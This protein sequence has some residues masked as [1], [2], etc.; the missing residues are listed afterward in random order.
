MDSIELIKLNTLYNNKLTD[1]K[2]EQ[3]YSICL[4]KHK[5]YFIELISKN[6]YEFNLRIYDSK[7]NKIKFEPKNVDK[8]STIYKNIFEKYDTNEILS[9]KYK[10][11]LKYHNIDKKKGKKRDKKYK[12]DKDDNEDYDNDE[13][14]DEE[15]YD[16]EDYDDEKEN[17]NNY[18]DDYNKGKSQKYK[19]KYNNIINEQKEYYST[20]DDNIEDSDSE[21]IDNSKVAD[22]K[23]TMK[24]VV[25]ENPNN[26]NDN[27]EL[28][29]ELSPSYSDKTKKYYN[30]IMNNDNNYRFIDYNNKIYF[31]PKKTDEY[32]IAVVSDYEGEEG[33]Y[34]LIVK[35]VE[36]ISMTLEKKMSLNVDNIVKFK[37][38]YMSQK[39]T[40][41]LNMNKTYNLTS[42]NYGVK[43]YI[44]GEGSIYSNDN[45]LDIIFTTKLGGKYLIE[46]IAIDNNHTNI[47][48]LQEHY[49]LLEKEVKDISNTST[50]YS[51]NI[52]LTDDDSFNE[53]NEVLDE[54]SVILDENS[55]HDVIF[56]KDSLCDDIFSLHIENGELVLQK[57]N[58]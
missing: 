12:E 48:K 49:K 54:N 14:Y 10:D 34:S 13:D 42:N 8:K 9:D 58:T 26:P 44:F 24:L 20:E 1:N 17:E 46:I 16:D 50:Y 35:E 45:K 23:N 4:E 7:N 47:I 51:D 55:V 2:Y 11:K 39:F 36:D 30:N 38:K 22:K 29:I 3:L 28:V 21:D 56:M 57:I 53:S 37:K 5:Y 6:D 41:S 31:N 52:S 43:M 25:Y 19:D 15:D 27:I 33:E 40:I 32:I 18:E